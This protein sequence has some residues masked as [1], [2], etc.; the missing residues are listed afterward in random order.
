MP[1]RAKTMHDLA[2]EPACA[3]RIT[4]LTA[5]PQTNRPTAGFR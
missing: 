5:K 1:A 2:K 3:C 4:R